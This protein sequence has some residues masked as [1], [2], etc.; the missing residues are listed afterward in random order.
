MG[1][2]KRSPD[3]VRISP[4]QANQEKRS[5]AMGKQFGRKLRIGGDAPQGTPNQAGFSPD[6]APEEIFEI[7]KRLMKNM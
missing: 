2:H 6:Y 1:S 7:A 3:R 4:I 5:E